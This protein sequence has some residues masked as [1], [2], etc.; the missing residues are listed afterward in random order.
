M[1]QGQAPG[2]TPA[3]T[4][5]EQ[6]MTTNTLTRL[7]RVF[8]AP[9]LAVAIAAALAACGGG[10]DGDGHSEG[11]PP[12]TA[13]LALTAQGSSARTVSLG[14]KP[15]AGAEGY[16]LQR[17]AA[18]GD[19]TTIAELPADRRYHLDEGLAPQ[20]AYTYRIA[21]KGLPQLSP[22][23][24]S[25]T[26]GDA[27]PVATVP[28]SPIAPLAQGTVGAA[29]GTVASA[30]GAVS[31]DVPAGAF[32]ADTTVQLQ[33][34]SNTA[35]GGQEDGV[36]LSAAAAPAKPLRLTLAYGAALD[37]SAHGLAVAL[38]RSDGTWLSLPILHADHAARRL[39]VE[40]WP[41]ADATS[42]A[43]GKRRMQASAAAGVQLRVAKYLNLMLLP[44]GASV[45]V[46]GTQLLT[47]YA[48]TELQ[49]VDTSSSCEEHAGGELC[50]PMPVRELRALPLLNDK[51]GYAR[52]WLVE[53]VEGGN[54]TLGTVVPR[55]GEAGAV[56]TAPKRAP[57]PNPVKVSFRSRH[58]ASG[59][60][61]E[62]H[63]LVT[64]REPL[65]TGI[66]KGT[67]PAVDIGFNFGIEGVWAPAAGSDDTFL[68]TGRQSVIVV[69]VTC[70]G[71]ATPGSVPLPPGSL[72]IDR[73][74]SPPRYTLEVG[75]DW[76]TVI[77]G[78]CP[79][80]GSASVPMKVRSTHLVLEGTVSGDG[81]RIEGQALINGVQWEWALSSQL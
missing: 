78:S 58:Q 36:Q 48:R 53:G 71:F 40:L 68:A 3:I 73:S 30:D 54:A 17:K 19:W 15:V 18:G 5:T 34:L 44:R 55:S 76:D 61:V 80:H 70:T 38:Q 9:L 66:F 49:G 11:N 60:T 52:Q 41:P 64:V 32:P 75:S 31:L 37:D 6:P 51:P 63:S 16:T 62:L 39:T 23:E 33:S 65:W 46:Q 42:A 77:T 35:P 47:P 45:P 29:G 4:P 56:F 25:A 7:A 22:V 10:G 13:A 12:P 14:W 2:T 26:T 28:A 8:G 50:I 20:T 27:E 57:S 43:Q 79:G 81:T 1:C 24:R 72:K 74:T 59:R 69:P 21:A 67:G